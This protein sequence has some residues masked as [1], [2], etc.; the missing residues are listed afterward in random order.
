LTEPA[1]LLALCHDLRGPLGAIGTWLHVLGSGRADPATQQ[2]A[3]AAMQRDVGSQRRLIEQVSD[4][5][6]ILA[7]ALLPTIQDVELSSVVEPLGAQLQAQGALPTVRAD[8]ARLRQLLAILLGVIEGAAAMSPA[9]VLVAGAEGPGVL[10]IRG[11]AR[12]EG[13]GLVGLTLARALV[14]LQ[15]GRLEIAQAAEG[16]AFT[17]DLPTSLPAGE[18]R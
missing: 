7:G 17:I 8:P 2:Q 14:E 3:V 9:P 5:S 16:G 1:F 6:S 11:R 13:P 18:G 12:K 15:R 4:L 10:S